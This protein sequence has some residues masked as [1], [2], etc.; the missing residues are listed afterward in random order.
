M[1]YRPHI[2]GLRAVAIL[3][4]VAFHADVELFSGGFTGV[5]IFFVISGFL[6]TSL[7]LEELKADTFSLA[8][9]Y[10]RR[11]LRI[12]PAYFAM[13][14]GVAVAA[15]VLML[16]QGARDTGWTM[17]A[18]SLFASN[19]Y[20]WQTTDYFETDLAGDPLLH[21]WTLSVEEQFYIFLPLTL[22]LV[23]RWFQG[24]HAAVLILISLLSFIVSAWA[25]GRYDAANFYLLPTRAWEFGLGAIL[26][27]MGGRSFVGPK[28]SEMGAALGAALVVYGIFELGGRS[29]FPGPNALYPVIGA[30]LL[31]AFG[32]GTWVGR[33][34]SSL[35]FVAI[36]RISYS[37]Y[38]WHWPIMVFWRIRSG[39]IEGAVETATVIALSLAAGALSYWLIETP[40]RT[41]AMRDR[42]AKWVC[43]SGLGGIALAAVLGLVIT[44]FSRNW[45]AYPDEVL[46]LAAYADYPGTVD[47]VEIVGPE[48]CMIHADTPGRFEAFSPEI[49]L[50]APADKPRWLLFGDS[51]AG[52]LMNSLR[53]VSPDV[54][55]Q[56][57]GAS[58]C[59]PTVDAEG[60]VWC[61]DLVDLILNDHVADARLDGVVLSARWGWSDIP[62]LQETVSRLREH[63]DQIVILGPTIEYLDSFPKVLARG[64]LHGD[65]NAESERFINV[66][67]RALDDRM[68]ATDW[69]AN[70]RYVSLFDLLCPNGRCPTLTP[71]GVPYHFDYGHFTREASHEV[72]ERLKAVDIF[73]RSEE[74]LPEPGPREPQDNRS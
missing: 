18:A 45:R 49:C 20:F 22:L 17:A 60:A 43:G 33:L 41:P 31:I 38:L 65:K 40:F 37:V 36:G 8:D 42:P 44:E 7:I 50:P 52:H 12:L 32:A 63:I 23:S 11:A 10:K 51:H 27:A 61:E 21:T 16:P 55:L 67:V 47:W 35:P 1:K 59:R 9:F 4:V 24:R 30:T 62:K 70:V 53:R 2:D 5:D 66:Q 3:P 15:Y 28:T 26:A 56:L 58:G 64:I 74:P 68:A 14:L 25:V 57:A 19:I 46:R 39:P 72:A 71:G 29:E 34:L 6:I 73:D 13:I 48:Q 69:G 54:A